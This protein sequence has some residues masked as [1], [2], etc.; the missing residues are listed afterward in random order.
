METLF[1]FVIFNQLSEL[2]L[3]NPSRNEAVLCSSCH[4]MLVLFFFFFFNIYFPV[5]H[6]FKITPQ[7][8]N[9]T[10]KFALKTDSSARYSQTFSVSLTYTERENT[11]AIIDTV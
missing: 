2:V 10:Y 6:S 4:V 11:I 7:N 1:F 8:T 5:V 3:R 9:N